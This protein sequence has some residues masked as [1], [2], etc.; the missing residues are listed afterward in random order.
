MKKSIIYLSFLLCSLFSSCIEKKQKSDLPS[1]S[2]AI[3]SVCFQED[4]P[5]E[6]QVKFIND[7][8]FFTINKNRITFSDGQ[9]TAYSRKDNILSI[10][11][12]GEE[13]LFNMQTLP[14][15]GNYELFV[16]HKNVK[17]LKIGIREK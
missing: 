16:D 10:F 1:G 9:E 5:V 13:I 11:I 6:E 8:Q 4:V 12:D 17:S 14:D 15:E 2:Y 3:E 7:Y